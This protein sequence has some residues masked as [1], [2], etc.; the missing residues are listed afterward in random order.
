MKLTRVLTNPFGPDLI[1][2]N[3]I[4][5]SLGTEYYLLT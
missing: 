4:G 2:I 5:D 3:V 1:P